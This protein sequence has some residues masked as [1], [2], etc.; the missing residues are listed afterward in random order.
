MYLTITRL[1]LC[2]VVQLLR[3]HMD[4]PTSSHLAAAYKIIIYIKAAPSQGLLFPSSSTTFQLKSYC[5]SDWALCPHTRWSTTGNCIFLGS[6]LVSWKSK[7]QTVVSRSFAKSEYRA[8]ATTFLEL[9]WLCYLLT[10][11]GISH[12]QVSSLVFDNQAALHIT[13]NLVFHE[14]KKHIELNCHLVQDQIQA[15]Y[16]TTAHVSSQT[17]LANIFTK[18]LPSHLLYSH[19]L[20][21]GIVNYYSPSCRRC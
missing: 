16:V 6:S 15:G 19:L 17:Q 7:K 8:M 18:V 4:S 9:T 11:I 10:D 1:D 12:P 3:Q 21:M 20:K 2:F 5:D 13:A 14:R